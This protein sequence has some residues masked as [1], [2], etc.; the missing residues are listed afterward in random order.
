MTGKPRPTSESSEPHFL[1]RPGLLFP[2][3]PCGSRQHGAQGRLKDDRPF[4]GRPQGSSLT[5]RAPCYALAGRGR[6]WLTVSCRILG[7]KEGTKSGVEV[8]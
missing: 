3:R 6:L 8:F 1:D 4:G 7:P 5:G 2:T